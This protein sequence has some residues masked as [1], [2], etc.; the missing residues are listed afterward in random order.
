MRYQQNKGS[1]P[2]ALLTQHIGR[3]ITSFFETPTLENVDVFPRKQEK[4]RRC[5]F[6]VLDQFRNLTFKYRGGIKKYSSINRWQLFFLLLK[7]SR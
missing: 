5:S 2:A 3:P 7:K 4:P 1:Y 6:T